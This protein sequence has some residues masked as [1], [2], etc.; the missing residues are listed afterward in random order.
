MQPKP[1]NFFAGMEEAVA[2]FLSLVVS[3]IFFSI[4][5]L[6]QNPQRISFDWKNSMI[7]LAIFWFIYEFCAYFLFLVLIQFSK[8]KNLQKELEKNKAE[9]KKTEEPLE[10][11]EILPENPS[12]IENLKTLEEINTEPKIIDTKKLNS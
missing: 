4:N 11:L 6:S 3:L 7:Y 1:N 10:N 9:E 2:R 8:N 12:S 5:I